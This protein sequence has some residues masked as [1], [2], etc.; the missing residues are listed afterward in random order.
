MEHLQT[1]LK[2]ADV[3]KDRI[4]GCASLPL[5]KRK[6]L[7][8]NLRAEF[9]YSSNALEG[10]ELT[11]EET[12]LLLD[13]SRTPG[14]RLLKDCNLTAGCAK[15]Y[16][17]MMQLA[18]QTE[19]HVS[20]EDTRE[21]HYLLYHRA[22]IENAGEYRTSRLHP[23][24]ADHIPSAPE[25]IP[26]LMAHFTDQ[27][28]FSRTILHPIELAAMAHKRLLDI[29]PF[30]QGNG[31]IACLLMNLL[32]VNS[33]YG[34][35]VILPEDREDYRNALL[36][37]RR[38]HDIEPFSKFTAACVLRTQQRYIQDLY[39]DFPDQYL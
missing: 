19:R 2:R 22:E 28:Y 4:Q 25:E 11:R 27:I 16:D 14:D 32:L 31:Q 26:R 15:A 30:A 10:N 33:G 5:V 21:F 9:V 37:S 39:P 18:G 13:R 20:E 35:T 1:L 23:D 3:Y 7:E 29:Q 12:K 36:T 24:M 17:F 8:Q 6:E 34:I 38:L